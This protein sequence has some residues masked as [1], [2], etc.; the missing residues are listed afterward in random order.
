MWSLSEHSVK[1]VTLDNSI[2]IAGREFR[3]NTRK[4]TKKG[5]FVEILN[6]I[7][8]NLSAMLSYHCKVFIVQ[9]VVHCHEHEAQNRGVSR[10]MAVF[11]K[12]LFSRYGKCRVSGGWVRETGKSGIQH[13][14]VALFLDG[15]KVRWSGRVQELINEI[16][17]SRNYP[18]AS[19]TLA[20]MLNRF[21]EQ[22]LQ[23]VFYHLSY[24]AKTSTKKDRLPA[25]NDFSFSRLKPRTCNS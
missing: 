13:Y 19:F 17:D 7:E 11:K 18:I 6:A 2:R 16:L 12:R 9:F 4:T 1:R 23:D 24:L 14:H 10:L 25:T 15:N 20:H 22:K 8:A 21:D 3:I 5:C